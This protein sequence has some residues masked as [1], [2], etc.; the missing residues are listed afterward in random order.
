M[1][2]A[3]ELEPKAEKISVTSQNNR[4]F[5]LKVWRE[6]FAYMPPK[7]RL[8]VVSAAQSVDPCFVCGTKDSQAVTNIL[9][10]EYKRN[11]AFHQV[12][13]N[14]D[15]QWHVFKKIELAI[16][17]Y[18]R[19]VLE[20][21]TKIAEG[22]LYMRYE[23]FLKRINELEKKLGKAKELLDKNGVK[24]DSNDICISIAPFDMSTLAEYQNDPNRFEPEN[25]SAE[26]MQ[27]Y[28]KI[29]SY[30]SNLHKMFLDYEDLKK[31]IG[32]IE[33]AASDKANEK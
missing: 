27:L 23:H 14:Q 24:Y 31:R 11:A 12:E 8:D 25:A 9:K 28:K 2:K 20:R 17:D 6:K 3:P 16:K 7:N 29:E 10:E 30:S 13:N 15:D 5:M 4:D 26:D 32:A 22:F 19:N 18:E 33:A 1:T 21:A